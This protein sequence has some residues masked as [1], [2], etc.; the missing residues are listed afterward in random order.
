MENLDQHRLSSIATLRANL[1]SQISLASE[2][3]LL[4]TNAAHVAALV[5]LVVALLLQ[6]QC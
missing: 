4:D 5:G 6:F 1:Q 3:K 2:A